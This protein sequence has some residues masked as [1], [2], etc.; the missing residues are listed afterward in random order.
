[1]KRNSLAVSFILTC[2]LFFVLGL[3]FTNS[4]PAETNTATPVLRF[5]AESRFRIVQ[6]TDIHWN[7]GDEKNLQSLALMKS[8]LDIEKPN[9]V[10]LT[11]DIISGGPTKEPTTAIKTVLS[12]MIERKIPWAY[13]LGN[14]DGEGVYSKEQIIQLAESLPY[15]LTSRGPTNITG[16]GN[17]WLPVYSSTGDKQSATIY[18]IDSNAYE[19]T[20]HD[21]YD[22]IYPNQIQWYRETSLKLTA[23][24]GG[25]PLPALAFFHI[26]LPEFNDI[27]NTGKCLG[28]KNETI[29]SPKINSGFLAAMLEMGDVMGLYV[30][31]DHY[32]DFE[33]NWYGIR[34]GYGR[35]TGYTKNVVED[36]PRGARVIELQ[37]NSRTYSTWIRV[38]G[39]KKITY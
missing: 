18:C 3:P 23:A 34:I 28:R 30:G 24:N 11:G 19:K 27:W 4:Q 15:S 1:M 25:T 32:N 21:N 36:M 2:L 38:A 17:Y 5:T 16:V 6:F 9:L 8:I 13:V 7:D 10:V 12:P 39:G 14:H 35:Q 31:H 29:C 37:E 26:P 22:W 20:N 33:G